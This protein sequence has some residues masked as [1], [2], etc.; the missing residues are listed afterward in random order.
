MSTTL[1]SQPKMGF[2][3]TSQDA[4]EATVQTEIISEI[5]RVLELEGKAIYTAI[6]RVKSSS[7]TQQIKA[8]I[9]ELSHCLDRGGK[10]VVTGVG[11]SGK[12]GQKIAATLSST[13]SQAVFLHPTEGMHGDLGLVQT[14]DCVLALSYTGNTEELVRLLPSL[15][16]LKS[17]IIGMG[18]N[19]QSELGKN[20]NY[21]I[22]VGVEAEA[23]PHNLAPTCSTTLTLAMGDAIAVAL[24]K[25]R[26][27]NV[28]AFARNHPGGSLGKKLNLTVA[29][30]M[31]AAPAVGTVTRHSSMDEVIIQATEKKLGGVLVVEKEK[32]LGIITDGDIRRALKYREAFFSL[33]AEQVMTIAPITVH[34]E[35]MAIDAL[36]LMEDRESQISVLP[37]V[38]SFG[39][40]KGL[41]RLHDLARCF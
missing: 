33:K 26:K 35:A 5:L 40:W 20:C 36:R 30:S 12:I 6:E 39:H 34:P 37:V 1:E 10:I 4:S 41:I 15:R 28:E 8:V 31:H 23:C 32:L 2:R 24:M 18:G 7:Q 16:H 3:P 19:Q 29:D 25:L 27:F 14:E 21:W 11:K 17:T 38:D 9:C 22:D 13:G